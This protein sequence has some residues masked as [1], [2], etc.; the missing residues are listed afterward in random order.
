MKIC[1]VINAIFRRLKLWR[2]HNKRNK[3]LALYGI[4]AEK[5]QLRDF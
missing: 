3:V 5:L 4:W 1:D 2:N